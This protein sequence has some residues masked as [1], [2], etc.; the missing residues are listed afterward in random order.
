MTPA[1][2]ETEKKTRT[3]WVIALVITAAALVVIVLIEAWVIASRAGY[4]IEI[5]N[6]ATW[7]TAFVQSAPS[8]VTYDPVFYLLLGTRTLLNLGAGLTAV[9]AIIWFVCDG[10]RRYVMRTLDDVLCIRDVAL[11]GY[12]V[13]TLGDNGVSVSGEALTAVY[14]AAKKF[15]DTPAARHFER[16]AATSVN[17]THSS[18]PTQESKASSQTVG[19]K[20]TNESRS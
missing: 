15:R 18:E 4:W 1:Q 20:P 3:R 6:G 11:A 13:K 2:T 8:T 12:I 14:D 10:P 5:F 7:P 17:Q 19:S 16:E 9:I